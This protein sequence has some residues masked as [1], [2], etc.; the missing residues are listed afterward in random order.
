[1]TRNLLIFLGT[2]MT[3][4]LIA[5]VARAAMFQPHVAH[6]A[7]A[8]GGGDY[9]PMVSNALTPAT[10]PATAPS[11]TPK[12]ATPARAE[13]DHAS[14]DLV[15]LK[16][17]ATKETATAVADQPV[18]TV[19]AICGMDVDPKL[20]SAQY[21]GKTIGFGCKMCPPKFKADPDRWGP[22]YLKNEVVKR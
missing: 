3:G 7:G 17:N 5:L 4:A 11:A 1:M 6:E 21:Q 15:A 8:V 16:Q 12:K 18:N 9:A 2:F 19:C 10:P 22:L 20:P 14:H 13:D